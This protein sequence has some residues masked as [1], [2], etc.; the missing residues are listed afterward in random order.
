LT[1]PLL[2][3]AIACHLVMTAGL[4]YALAGIG[5]F[6][7][8]VR[9]VVAVLLSIGLFLQPIFYGPGVAPRPLELV[10]YLSPVSYLIWCYRDALVYGE[11][12]RPVIWLVTPVMSALLFLVGYR[13][14]RT[15]QP[16]FGNAL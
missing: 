10:F 16:A 8:D 14:Y 13:L 3:V 12:T 11:L 4:V 7:R 1:V 5:V 9:D 15:L 6:I 2:I